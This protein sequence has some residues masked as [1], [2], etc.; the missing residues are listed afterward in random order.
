MCEAQIPAIGNHSLYFWLIRKIF[1]QKK[2]KKNQEHSNFR[3]F[4]NLD[5]DHPQPSHRVPKTLQMNLISL[6]AHGTP[7]MLVQT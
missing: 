4:Y 6:F 2:T 1:A 3:Y 5:P 7:Y